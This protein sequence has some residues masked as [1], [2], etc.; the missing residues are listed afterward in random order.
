LSIKT[1]IKVLLDRSSTVLVIA[2]MLLSIYGYT[3]LPSFIPLR[4]D[5]M[6]NGHGLRAKWIVFAF[7]I[8][9]ILTYVFIQL[10]LN[11]VYVPKRVK[12]NVKLLKLYE[13]S[14]SFM[15]LIRLC[16]LTAIFLTLTLIIIG[17]FTYGNMFGLWYNI[18]IGSILSGPVIW[19]LREVTRI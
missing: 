18:I 10:L 12:Y 11:Y 9:A 5:R 4:I 1:D 15:Q 3:V 13:A 17:N 8:A 6:G 14:N 7:P 16:I 2:V 19:Y